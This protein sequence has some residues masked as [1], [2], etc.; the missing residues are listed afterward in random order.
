ML[1]TL[2]GQ[3]LNLAYAYDFNGDGGAADSM[4]DLNFRFDTILRPTSYQSW[5]YNNSTDATFFPQALI[6]EI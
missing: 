6:F 5:L 3:H 1:I 4:E 2:N